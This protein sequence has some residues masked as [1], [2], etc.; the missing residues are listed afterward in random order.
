MFCLHSDETKKDLE[1]I[2]LKDK[3]FFSAGFL[4]LGRGGVLICSEVGRGKV[5]KVKDS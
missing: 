2:I 4:E 5:N 3:F 1:E